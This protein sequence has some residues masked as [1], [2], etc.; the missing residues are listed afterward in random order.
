MNSHLPPCLPISSSAGSPPVSGSRR[1]SASTTGKPS[2][3]SLSAIALPIPEDDPVTIAEP[4]TRA[5]SQPVPPRRSR[6]LPHDLPCLADERR[7]GGVAS[8]GAGVGGEIDPPLGGE[9]ARRLGG[10]EVG[11]RAGPRRGP[12]PGACGADRAVGAVDQ[13]HLT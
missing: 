11:A 9:R 7:G 8:E 2:A 12:E 3:S 6:E 1:T 10:P 4:V 5:L 13:Q